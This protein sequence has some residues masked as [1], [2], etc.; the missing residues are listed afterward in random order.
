M[1]KEDQSKGDPFDALKEELN[2]KLR[3]LISQLESQANTIAIQLETMRQHV[4]AVA[5]FVKLQGQRMAII[6]QLQ[7]LT[8][9]E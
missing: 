9:G 6:Q 8:P 4:P 3:M 5:E 2:P 7:Q 1:S